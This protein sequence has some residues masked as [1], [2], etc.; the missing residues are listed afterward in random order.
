MSPAGKLHAVRAVGVLDHEFAAVV[1]VRLGEKQRR[2]D[3]GAQAHAAGTRNDADRTVDVIVEFHAG[4]VAIEHRRQHAKR[5]SRRTEQ[6]A[7]R[8]SAQDDVA[9]LDRGRRTFRNLQVEFRLRGLIA[10]GAL[11]IDPMR[12]LENRTTL[13]DFVRRQQLRDMDHHDAIP[14]WPIPPRSSAAGSTF[15]TSSERYQRPR[16]AERRVA[17]G[18]GHR[19]ALVVSSRNTARW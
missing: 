13:R 4:I 15:D 10:G 6:R 11:A 16:N 8:Q 2:R 19:M 18:R 12:R 9:G 7:A 5:Q 17:R 14:E 1:V 3:I